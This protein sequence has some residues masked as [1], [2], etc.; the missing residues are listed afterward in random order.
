VVAMRAIFLFFLPFWLFAI[1]VPTPFITEPVE[2]Q[3]LNWKKC[4][5]ELGYYLF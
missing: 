3:R 5:E 4:E 1:L 2:I